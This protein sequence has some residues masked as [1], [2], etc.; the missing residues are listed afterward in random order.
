MK[1]IN[2]HPY[3]SVFVVLIIVFFYAMYTAYR[4]AEYDDRE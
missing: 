1:F 3:L 4:D 2:D